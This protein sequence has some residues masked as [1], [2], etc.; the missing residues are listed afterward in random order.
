[1]GKSKKRS[2]K[3][4]ASEAIATEPSRLLLKLADR[5][6]GET[7]DRAAFVQS[8]GQAQ[9]F[10]PCLLWLA[11]RPDPF[12]F[13]ALPPLAMQPA[14]VDRLD[15]TADQPANRRPGKHPLHEAG[16]FYC[17]DFSSV[18]A[19]S[20][21]LAIP[22]RV[23]RLVDLCAAP[24]GKSVFAWRALQPSLL[25]ANEA[26]G[27]RI[28]MLVSNLKRC[29]L[30]PAIATCADP[31]TLAQA[32]P[33]W[34]DLVIVDAPCSGQSLLAKGEKNP[35]CFHPLTIGKNANRQK[36]I[37]ANAAALVAP[38][39]WLAYMTCTY[40]IEENEGATQWLLDRFPHLEPQPVPA[41]EPWRSTHGAFPCY[42]MF[43]QE[44]LGA[45]SFVV[46]LRDER[47]GPANPEPANP[48]PANPGR[49][50]LFGDHEAL[51][52]LIRWRSDR[53]K[54]I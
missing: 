54:P 53:S 6:F 48:G 13:A 12:P 36:R 40:A 28:G 46:L 41:L 15:L 32:I 5:L 39:G 49:S 44:G 34:A 25:V 10:A 11:D 4:A 14:W 45:G 18:F 30:S 52:S 23:D 29:G 20:A 35:G 7:A 50:S 21:L 42:R 33:G 43:P 22:D 47:N 26:I 38:G 17:L 3:P 37:L 51:Q 8:L 1:M 24:G 31:E 2:A 19:A 27:K 16:A 9:R